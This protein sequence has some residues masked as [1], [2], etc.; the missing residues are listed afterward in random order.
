MRQRDE[1]KNADN[2][3]PCLSVP[4]LFKDEEPCHS[5]CDNAERSTVH[6]YGRVALADQQPA[7]Q[8]IRTTR[9]GRM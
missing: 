3:L 5:F 1:H 8:S 9:V 4:I 6:G 7:A 2:E